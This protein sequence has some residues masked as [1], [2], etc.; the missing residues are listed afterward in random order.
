LEKAIIDGCCILT[1]SKRFTLE[2]ICGFLMSGFS[3]YCKYGNKIKLLL[4]HSNG[5]IA[6]EK[7]DFATIVHNTKHTHEFQN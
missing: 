2:Q 7:W 5:S 1:V 6:R 4:Q 3:F